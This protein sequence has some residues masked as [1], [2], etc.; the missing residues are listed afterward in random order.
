MSRTRNP[1]NK[2]LPKRWRLKHGAYYYA[3]P[4]EVRHLWDGKQLFRLGKNLSEAHKAY[5]ERAEIHETIRLISE[6]L[7]DYEIKV[8]PTKRPKTQR[9]NLREIR[10]L[11]P[12]FGDMSIHD[13]RPKDIYRYH[14]KRL[15][16]R[17]AKMEINVLS[18]AFTK[19]V[20]W[21]YI[22]R[23]PFKG[24]VI[25]KETRTREKVYVEDMHI[26]QAI[27]LEPR[28][29][30]DWVTRMMRA[31]VRLKYITGLRMTDMLRLRPQDLKPDGLHISHNKTIESSG[32]R[33]IFSPTPA[34]LEAF[35]E[36]IAA[37]PV[38]I[39]PWVFCTR[40]GECYFNE[41]TGEC[42]GFNSL[43]QRWMKR[44]KTQTGIKFS[45]RSIRVKTGS[46]ATDL[47][48]AQKLLGH[49]DAR[50][51]SKFYRMGADIVEPLKQI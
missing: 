33:T 50:T 9:N 10:C 47:N 24:E 51:T 12:V 7:H 17:A 16:K 39:A 5:A 19:A 25:I 29:K 3:V 36:A 27:S 21:G 11:R 44:V 31:Y 46:D 48:Q 43:W 13:I 45:E 1:E 49:A 6:L 23:H 35:A 14:A 20:E 26:L 41:A 8:I 32:K 42:Y 40:R 4:D 22:D 34:L 18:H 28:G 37:R 2:G 15:G 38:H 30:K